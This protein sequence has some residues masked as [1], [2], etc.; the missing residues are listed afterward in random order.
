MAGGQFFVRN[1]LQHINMLETDDP[2]PPFDAG[3]GGEGVR[4][5]ALD[6]HEGWM[7]LI[8]A[9]FYPDG[10]ERF[11]EY[12]VLHKEADT[13]DGESRTAKTAGRAGRR[14]GPAGTRAAGPRGETAG[15]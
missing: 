2:D 10:H 13:D 8:S 4:F 6:A 1:I 7:R 12:A 5:W 9:E 11:E 14:R 15:G 3:H